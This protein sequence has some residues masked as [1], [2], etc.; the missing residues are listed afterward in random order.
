MVNSGDI[1]HVILVG[2]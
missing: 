2:C 1:F